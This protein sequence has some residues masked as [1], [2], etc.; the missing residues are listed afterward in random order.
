MPGAGE[1]LGPLPTAR[2]FHLHILQLRKMGLREVQKWG[3]GHTARK[4]LSSVDMGAGSGD[5]E[6]TGVPGGG[7]KGGSQL[8]TRREVLTT[9]DGLPQ[10]GVSSSSSEGCEQRGFEHC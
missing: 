4:W 5:S 8:S 3:Q 1:Y 6:G 10:D 2:C 7:W 9:A